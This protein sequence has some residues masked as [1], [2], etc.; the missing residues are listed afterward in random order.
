[1][2][3]ESARAGKDGSVVVCGEARCRGNGGSQDVVNVDGW[4]LIS[5]ELCVDV[6]PSANRGR[7]HI[8][9]TVLDKNK[10]PCAIGRKGDI[11]LKSCTTPHA[12]MRE[13]DATSRCVGTGSLGFKS[14]WSKFVPAPSAY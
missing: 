12:G 10:E 13:R 14:S 2:A 8:A 7:S 3:R 11:R 1:M 9:G 5:N 6:S 4:L